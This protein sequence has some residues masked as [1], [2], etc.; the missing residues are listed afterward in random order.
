MNAQQLLKKAIL[1]KAVESKDIEPFNLNLSGDEI[2]SLYESYSENDELRDAWSEIRYSGIDA[3]ELSP[4]TFSGHY[5]IDVK[6]IKIDG[7]WVAFDFYYGGGK[8]GEPEDYAFIDDARIV[9]CE[10]KQITITAYN[11]SD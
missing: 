8:Y 1:L 11:F 9:S 3:H 6:A 7:V 2:D 10:E 4:V 5:E